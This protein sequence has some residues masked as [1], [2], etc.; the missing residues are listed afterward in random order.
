MLGSRPTCSIRTLQQLALPARRLEQLE[1]LRGA[2]ELV[3]L[4]LFARVRRAG[5]SRVASASGGTGGGSVRPAAA[6]GRAAVKQR[7]RAFLLVAHALAHLLR[8]ELEHGAS[9]LH[10]GHAPAAVGQLSL[11]LL[12]LP[13]ALAERLLEA[14]ALELCDKRSSIRV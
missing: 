6:I 3:G 7:G 4:S 14:P 2:A 9:L 12:D 8:L 11:E 5:G 10:D 1:Q 13:H